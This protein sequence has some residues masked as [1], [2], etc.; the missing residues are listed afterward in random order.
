MSNLDK[1]GLNLVLGQRIVDR[2]CGSKNKFIFIKE[3][4]KR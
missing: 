3:N 2:L 4:S 1:K